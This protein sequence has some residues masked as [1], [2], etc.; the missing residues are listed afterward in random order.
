MEIALLILVIGLTGA[1]SFLY[2]KIQTLEKRDNVEL[3]DTEYNQ[4]ISEVQNLIHKKLQSLGRDIDKRLETN[5]F[6]LDM[7]HKTTEK[8][9]DELSNLIRKI[10]DDS[11]KWFTQELE[12]VQSENKKYIDS[13]IDFLNKKFFTVI[14]LD[15]K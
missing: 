7:L 3:S 6:D 1:V 5:R 11:D 2:S 10:E 9:T 8:R 4:I 15:D 14:N 13:R 12:R